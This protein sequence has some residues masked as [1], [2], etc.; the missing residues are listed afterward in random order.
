MEDDSVPRFGKRD[1]HFI[2]KRSHEGK[3]QDV[4]RRGPRSQQHKRKRRTNDTKSRNIGTN[5]APGSVEKQI[6]DICSVCNVGDPKYKCP[7]CRSTYCSIDCC[8][9][10]KEELC[11]IVTTNTTHVCKEGENSDD[12]VQRN[13]YS[14]YLTKSELEQIEDE[15]KL[16]WN[17]LQKRLH[18]DAQADEDLGPGWKMTENMLSIMRNSKWLREELADTG[19]QQLI[20]KIVSSSKNLVKT[21]RRGYS[22]SH[23]QFCTNET[24][25]REQMLSNIKLQYPQFQLFLDKLLYL[26]EVYERSDHTEKNLKI[27]KDEWL[28]MN[29]QA[30]FALRPL[31]Q[32]VRPGS[33]SLSKPSHLSGTD[34]ESVK[35]QSDDDEGDET[36]DGTESSDDR[37][38]IAK[39]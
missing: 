11:S 10:H 33:T 6:T 22:T 32:R 5:T 3:E 23:Q 18:N 7:K 20:V 1:Q 35:T 8:R 2:H 36:D 25:Y 9:K 31:P 28:S 15:T 13:L 30:T 24:T 17:D 26:T 21:N 12:T 16:D 29:N 38:T 19:L 4:K 27:P 34:G 37:D 39:P 14:K